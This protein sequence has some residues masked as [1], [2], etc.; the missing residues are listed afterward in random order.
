MARA[1]AGTRRAQEASATM[2]ER[3]AIVRDFTRGGRPYEVTFDARTAFDFLISL[4][5]GDADDRDLA[6]QDHAWL[7]EARATLTAE[8]LAAVSDCFGD[9]SMRVFHGLA[10]TLVDRPEIRDAASVVRSIEQASTR[11]V[12]R[13]MLVDNLQEKVADDLIDRAIDGDAS[14]IEEL[15]PS[16][17][18]YHRGDFLKFLENAEANVDRLMDALQAWLPLFQQVE[19]RVADLQARDVAWRSDDRA[20]LDDGALIEKVTGGLRWLP[21][22][23][24]SRVILSPSYFSRPY[25][26]VYQG[27]TWRLFCY[28]MADDIL[29]QADSG[30]PPPSIVRLYRALGDST[31]MRVL[32]LLSERD[33]YLTELA[34]QLELSKPTMKHH[35]ALMRA[36]GLVTVTEEGSLTYYSLRR[37]RLEEAGLE[38]RRFIG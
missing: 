4:E 7:K 32:K 30:T 13:A 38:L 35:L 21:D 23:Q 5:I 28:P 31:R 15:Q 9:E 2:P 14:A 3:R 11:G 16:L 24:V 10:D 29:E 37:A 6:P 27:S 36:A 34:T 19:G 33:W 17:H 18:E 22:A 8:Q 26:Y 1:T 25:N 20:T 12:T